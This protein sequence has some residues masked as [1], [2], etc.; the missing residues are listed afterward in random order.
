MKNISLNP[1]S[2]LPSCY[3][4]HKLPS[5]YQ[6]HAS[7]LLERGRE[8]EHKAWFH[9]VTTV[10]VITSHIIKQRLHTPKPFYYQH[11]ANKEILHLSWDLIFIIKFTRAD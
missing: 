10:S 3:S 1:T 4:G 6:N 9:N 5:P 7:I 11:T 8:I 2:I